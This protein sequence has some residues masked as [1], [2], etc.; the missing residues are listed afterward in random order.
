MRKGYSGHS[1][2]AAA[3]QENPEPLMELPLDIADYSGRKRQGR[4]VLL[5]GWPAEPAGERPAAGED[6]RIVIL[7]EPP[8]SG[9]SP[10]EYVVVSAP[11][12]RLGTAT[13]APREPA[14]TY[15]AAKQSGLTLSPKDIDLLRQGS[16]FA[17]TPLQ[18]TAEDVF[19]GGEARLTLLARDLLACKA[20]EEHLRP[21]A[22]ALN[23]PAAAKPASQERLEELKQL[24]QA[25]SDIEFGHEASEGE[26]ALARLS[27]LAFAADAERFLACAERIYP[28]RQALMEDIYMLRAFLQSPEQASELL[29]MQRFLRQVLVPADEA[30]LALDRSVAVEQLTFA[31]LAV[32]PQLMPPARAMLDSF[33]KKYISE[34][35]EHHTR[36][37]AQMARLHARLR[38]EQTLVEALH[39]L[40][41]LAEL[42]TPVG[43]GALA[44]YEELVA[45]TAGCPLISGVE[46][47][48]ETEAVC[49]A[50]SL[51]LDQPAPAQ[52]IDEILTRIDRACNRQM[53]RLSSSALQQVLRRSNDARVE[54]FLKMIQASQLSSLREILDDELVGYL[55]RFLVESR[56]EEA[57]QPILNQLQEGVPPKVDEAQTAMR[58]V[59][60]VLQRAFQ[61]A[62]RALPPG[63]APVTDSRP[64]RRKRKR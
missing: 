63:E 39:R 61:A 23:A 26:A 42:G 55:R 40:N 7:S 60:Q 56:I 1:S 5:P 12:R 48:L 59:S 11:T 16:L 17:A 19:A 20:L 54:Q 51:S 50:C 10:A 58:E 37:W 32:E 41:S 25:A 3:G 46:E 52:R 24:V 14:A 22:I 8:E 13:V 49:P 18:V 4:A 33:R 30:E 44:A 38:E 45:E 28:N 43:V 15:G 36:F 57:L 27:E 35:R 34:Y 47:M 21:I 2:S 64:P 6:F 9:V 62:Q 29:S 53:A 31:T